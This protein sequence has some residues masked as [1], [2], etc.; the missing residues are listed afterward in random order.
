MLRRMA[1][2]TEPRRSRPRIPAVYGVPKSAKGMLPWSHV[3]G[4]LA[5]ARNYWVCTTR[6]DG[7]PHAVPVWGVF[8]AGRVYHGGGEDTRHCRN[9]DANPALTIHLE[10]GDDVVIIEGTAEKLTEQTADPDVLRRIDDAY[11]AKYGMRHGTPVWG[12]RPRRVLAWSNGLA[13]A[14]RWE[15]DDDV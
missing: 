5:A 2:T 6:S 12:L 1:T 9:L 3:T 7:R 13:T 4:R 10:S 8:V 14:T 11:E 15:F